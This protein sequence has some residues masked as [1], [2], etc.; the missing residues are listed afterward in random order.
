MAQTAFLKLKKDHNIG[1]PIE[2]ALLVNGEDVKG[3]ENRWG[4]L[5]YKVRCENVGEDY[6]T[7]EPGSFTIK[8][9]DEFELQASQPLMSK[10]LY[11]SKGE[12]AVIE[13]CKNE[14]KPGQVFWKVEPSQKKY[15]KEIKDTE[16]VEQKPYG[17]NSVKERDTDRRLD[18]VWGMA[19]NNATRLVANI[20]T[21]EGV[22]DKVAL[23][24]DIMPKMFEIARGLDAVL[25]Q[26]QK[27]ESGDDDLPF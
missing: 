16:T 21:D 26:E 25:E 5:E 17:Y 20:S 11:F 1:K 8:Q 7:A 13:L 10:L 18:I 15:D 2:V 27:K 3:E 9:G 23:I 19:F 12:T 22:V 6:L 14:S 4:K 24:K